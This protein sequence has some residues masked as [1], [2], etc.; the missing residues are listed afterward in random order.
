M[1]K[2]V[3]KV[4]SW[5][6]TKFHNKNGDLHNAKGPA[7]KTDFGDGRWEHCWYLCGLKHRV[8]GPAEEYSDGRRWWYE[9]GKLH[10]PDGPAVMFPGAYSLVPAQ[11]WIHGVNVTQEEFEAQRLNAAVSQ[12][13]I[14]R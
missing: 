14:C 1:T 7:L 6:I 12:L 2:T 9:S 5:E 10:N 4:Y 13:S 3:K 11:Y 8:G